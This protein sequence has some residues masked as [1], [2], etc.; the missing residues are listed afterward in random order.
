M[1][2]EVSDPAVPSIQRWPWLDRWLD[3]MLPL[4]LLTLLV[5]SKREPHLMAG[6]V[7]LWLVLKL[8]NRPASAPFHGVLVLLLASQLFTILAQSKYPAST[9]SDLLVA[10][11]AFA[12]GYLQTR[13]QWQRNLLWVFCLLPVSLLTLRPEQVSGVQILTL[14]DINRN[15]SAFLFGLIALL[16]FAYARKGEGSRQRWLGSATALL[17]Y[18]L[19]VATGSRAGAVIP[20]LAAGAALVMD[21]LTR[22]RKR[23]SV[24]RTIAASLAALIVLG[25]IGWGWYAPQNAQAERNQ[26]SDRGRLAVMRCY[27]EQALKS[28]ESSMVGL[29][30]GNDRVS[31]LCAHTTPWARSGK[32]VMHA[33]N[34]FV[35]TFAENGAITLGL[36]VAVLLWCG[37]ASWIALAAWPQAPIPLASAAVVMFVLLF[38]QVDGTLIRFPLQQVLQGYLLA[39]PFAFG[40]ALIQRRQA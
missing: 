4:S 26:L 7:T 1:S 6:M 22:V 8:I 25:S 39:L 40:P 15:R 14:L 20:L 24:L 38:G 9:N 31:E 2:P 18:G 17:S 35:Q 28:F 10:A 5:D 37:R 34:T 36:L 32:G 12:C 11:T 29:G 21:R 33:H 27:G 3:L 30:Q 19:A 13:Q 16:A 23:A